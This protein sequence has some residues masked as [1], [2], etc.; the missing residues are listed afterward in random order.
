ML[1][2]ILK[3]VWLYI[4]CHCHPSHDNFSLQTGNRRKKGSSKFKDLLSFFPHNEYHKVLFED[5]IMELNTVVI[6]IW[7]RIISP[8]DS[9]LVCVTY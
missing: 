3:D 4:F 7:D 2:Q 8:W 1:L 9:G 6:D 5:E